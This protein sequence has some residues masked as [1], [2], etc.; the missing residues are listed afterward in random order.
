MNLSNK[1]IAL[2]GPTGVGKTEI[3]LELARLTNSEIISCDSMQ[4]YKGMDVGT[5]KV[6]PQEAL[7]VK[8][9][10]VDIIEPTCSYSVCDYVDDAKK[11]LQSIFEKGKNA[12]V[13]GGTGLYVD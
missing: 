10:L 3:S 4:I 9:H 13:V 12:L 1:V 7:K 11:A 8:H 5:A 6:S 2:V